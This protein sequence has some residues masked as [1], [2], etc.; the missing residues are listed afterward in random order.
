M[1]VCVVWNAVRYPKQPAYICE[2]CFGPLEIACDYDKIK[3]FI[4]QEKIS[5][6]QPTM[7]RFRELL[8]VSEPVY[9]LSVGYTPLVNAGSSGA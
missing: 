4:T 5:E 6:R 7:W 3:S 9:E 2:Y 1:K 8:P